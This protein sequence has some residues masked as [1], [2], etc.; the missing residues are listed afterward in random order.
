MRKFYNANLVISHL[1]INNPSPSPSNNL[2]PGS[3]CNLLPDVRGPRPQAAHAE[4]GVPVQLHGHQQG[5]G[6]GPAGVHPVLQAER[7]ARH[8]HGFT[9]LVD[10][11]PNSD[12][13]GIQLE[14]SEQV[15]QELA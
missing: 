6:G 10:F 11:L 13:L 15:G 8:W 14:F 7:A 12:K 3:R 9:A 5:W 1:C 2:C 4:G